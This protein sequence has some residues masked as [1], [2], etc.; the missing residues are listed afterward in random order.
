MIMEKGRRAAQ[1]WLPVLTLLLEK[2]WKIVLV[3]LPILLLLGG[4]KL[5]SAATGIPLRHFMLD[6]TEVMQVPFYTGFVSNLGILM[7][8]ATAAICLFVSIF[9]AQWMS[10]EWRNFLLISGLFT[11]LLLLDDLFRF[12]DELF[13]V[14]LGIEGDILGIIY[15]I[16]IVIYLI[17]FRGLIFQYS[18]GF[19]LLAFG[20]FAVSAA[21]DVPTKFLKDFFAEQNLLLLEDGAKLLGLANWLAYFTYI[22]ATILGEGKANRTPSRPPAG[23]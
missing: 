22:S 15:V 16:L 2:G 6:P 11:L 13:P 20:L 5:I 8:A 4:T 21:I 10:G 3:C 1:V 7:W 18:Y 14:Y 17:R 23:D 12:H 19:L 9:L